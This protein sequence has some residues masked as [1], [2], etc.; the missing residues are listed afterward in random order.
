M[1]KKRDRTI[2]IAKVKK[3]RRSQLEL[4]QHSKT[5]KKRKTQE[6]LLLVIRRRG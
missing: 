6:K 4:R 3:E 2:W 5:E 1:A